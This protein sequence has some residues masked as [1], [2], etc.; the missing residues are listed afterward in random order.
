MLSP[1]STNEDF[2]TVRLGGTMRSRFFATLAVFRALRWWFLAAVASWIGVGAFFGDV[3]LA[4][5]TAIAILAIHVIVNTLG[6]DPGQIMIRGSITFTPSRVYQTT[7]RGSVRERGWGWI[8]RA[9]DV[10]GQ[11]HIVI[12]KHQSRAI[13]LKYRQDHPDL[14]KLRAMLILRG[15][16]V[17]RE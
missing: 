3:L 13:G 14:R 4:A 11:L 8:V 1:H 15:K 12:G 16:L 2:V 9:E 5:E 6:V 17:V 7:W 10:F